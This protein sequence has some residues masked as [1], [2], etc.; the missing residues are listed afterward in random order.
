MH[1][2]VNA[3]VTVVVSLSDAG[4]DFEGGL[5][6]SAGGG[7]VEGG[8]GG[9]GGGGDGTNRVGSEFSIPD[10]GRLLFLFICNDTNNLFSYLLLLAKNKKR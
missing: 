8:G 2:D 10:F 6:V 1:F 4:V 5:Y 3:L 9:G 7:G